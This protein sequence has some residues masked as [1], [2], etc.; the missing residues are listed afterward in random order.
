M[1]AYRCPAD[2]PRTRSGEDG[3]RSLKEFG[4]GTLLLAVLV[5]PACNRE[6]KTREERNVEPA[7]MSA[8]P[9]PE[10]TTGSR[11]D[12]ADERFA[13]KHINKAVEELR[14]SVTDLRHA[15]EDASPGARK[16]LLDAANT[17]ERAGN[18]IRSKTITTVDAL[19]RRLAAA[20]A[21]L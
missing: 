12:A 11:L 1:T 20:N 14:L 9:E 5:V 18:D 8:T 7:R 4:A 10:P 13:R 16:D 2:L 17:I 15:A 21:S 3:M 6:N 19:E